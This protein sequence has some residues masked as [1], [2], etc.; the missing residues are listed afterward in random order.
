[1]PDNAGH[2]YGTNDTESLTILAAHANITHDTEVP[3]EPPPPE[4]PPPRKSLPSS[5][6][7]LIIDEWNSIMVKYGDTNTCAGRAALSEE[8]REVGNHVIQKIRMNDMHIK[9]QCDGGAN[10][11]VTSIK[12]ILQNVQNIPDY[13]I[14]DIGKGIK[15]TRRG[16]YYL[17]RRNGEVIPVKMYFSAEVKETVVSP[18]DTVTFHLDMFDS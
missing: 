1:M 13:H 18:T 11:S 15:C 3:V 16:I 9:I 6:N 12:S 17:Q 2:T 7:S 10:I 5:I 14:G 8:Q 4:P